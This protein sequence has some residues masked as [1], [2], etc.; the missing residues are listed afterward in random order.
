MLVPSPFVFPERP[1]AWGCGIVL[2][3]MTGVEAAMCHRLGTALERICKKD[4]LVGNEPPV[5]RF[6]VM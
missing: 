2:A 6:D 4:R 3:N 5:A 1:G